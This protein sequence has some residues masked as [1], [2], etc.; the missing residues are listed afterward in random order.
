MLECPKQLTTLRDSERKWEV[1][2]MTY[3]R[4]TGHDTWHF[5]RDCS[6]DPKSNFDARSTKPTTGE[7]CNE[8]ESKE[9]AGDCKQ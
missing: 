2:G 1:S 3:R 6:N 9:K 7:L 5:C 4:G 8:C